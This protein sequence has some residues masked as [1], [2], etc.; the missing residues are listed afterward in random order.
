MSSSPKPTER[1]PFATEP[2]QFAQKRAHRTFES[3]VE[4]AAEVFADRGFDGTQTP[5]IAARAKVSVGTF[6][7]YFSDK[8]EAFLEVLRRSLAKAHEAVMAELVPE[9]FVGAGRRKTIEQAIQILLDNIVTP[10]LQKAFLEMSLRDPA[11]AAL[12]LTFDSEARER[13]AQLIEAICPREV[14]PDPVATAYIVQTAVVE[15]AVSMSGVRGVPPVE[16]ERAF[17]SLADMVYRT[18]FGIDVTARS[19]SK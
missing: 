1:P 15:C 8:R 5:D 17:A 4:A 11:V 2:R 3:L 18:F 7:R 13:L 16:Q 19:E 12:R 6:Y 9:R 10:G 14:V